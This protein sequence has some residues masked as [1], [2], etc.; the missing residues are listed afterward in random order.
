MILGQSPRT[1][2]TRPAAAS[3]GFVPGLPA[4]VVNSHFHPL[5]MVM[6]PMPAASQWRPPFSPGMGP[7]ALPD[8]PAPAPAAPV[9]APKAGGMAG[10]GS[11]GGV[12]HQHVD[13]YRTMRTGMIPG[14][15]PSGANIRAGV[16]NAGGRIQRSMPFQT[17]PLPPPPPPPAPPAA[18]PAPGPV[19][20]FLGALFGR[21]RRHWRHKTPWWHPAP[22]PPVETVHT[23]SCETYGPRVDGVKVTV[24]AGRVVKMEDAQGNVITPNYG[25]M[26]G[27]LGAH[28]WRRWGRRFAHHAMPGHSPF[29]PF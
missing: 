9:V 28:G 25:P 21:P 14:V 19:A 6:N 16:R 8:V 17:A 11:T 1:S 24:C 4:T 7:H 18:A 27:Q 10:F 20:G 5:A 13:P 23:S 15:M 2:F 22:P 29:R 3:P 26:A 12:P